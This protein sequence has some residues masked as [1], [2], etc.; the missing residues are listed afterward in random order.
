MHILICIYIIYSFLILQA[1]VLLGQAPRLRSLTLSL[2]YND[3]RNRGAQALVA[4][5]ESP[6]GALHTTSNF[7]DH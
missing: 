6:R 3:I 5:R 7:C 2:S 1:L 4:L